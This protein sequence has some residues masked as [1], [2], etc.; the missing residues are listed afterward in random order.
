[1]RLYSRRRFIYRQFYLEPFPC[2]WVVPQSFGHKKT[3]QGFGSVVG[4][5]TN[6]FEALLSTLQIYL[7][8]HKTLAQ[9]ITLR[10]GACRCLSQLDQT[11]LVPLRLKRRSRFRFLIHFER[12]VREL[13]SS[14][15]SD[16]HRFVPGAPRF[17][18]PGV[19]LRSLLQ[20]MRS[21]GELRDVL[22]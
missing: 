17:H 22:D 4:S 12:C 11:R 14:R 7:R 2:P 1:M 8:C 13:P 3:S 21:M 19:I 16:Q 6:A 10:W 18:F 9:Q 15:P 20:G 5:T